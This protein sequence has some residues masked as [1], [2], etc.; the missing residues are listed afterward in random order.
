MSMCMTPLLIKSLMTKE[1]YMSLLS[2]ARK[3]YCKSYLKEHFLFD[4]KY[5]TLDTCDTDSFDIY[6]EAKLIAKYA[7]P[8]D[9]CVGLIYAGRGSYLYSDLYFR[10]GKPLIN[11]RECALDTYTVARAKDDYLQRRQEFLSSFPILKTS[12]TID[13]EIEALLRVDIQYKGYTC[14]GIEHDELI[15]IFKKSIHLKPRIYMDMGCVSF[16]MQDET[17]DPIAVLS[18]YFQCDKVNIF[19][20]DGDQVFP[21]TFMILLQSESK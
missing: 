15:A 16:Q 13:A 3:I 5:F 14:I 12:S 11:E 20:S 17:I 2:E 7:E 4:G 21:N 18:D 10:D 6:H 1:N 9:S 19:C 8:T